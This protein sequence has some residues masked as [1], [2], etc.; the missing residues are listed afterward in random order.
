MY[1]N[2]PT[3]PPPKAS[4]K[5]ISLNVYIGHPLYLLQ[6]KHSLIQSVRLD[7]QIKQIKQLNPDI[8]CLQEVYDRQIIDKYKETLHEYKCIYETEYPTPLQIAIT[9]AIYLVYY[10]IA[11]LSFPYIYLL[12]ITMQ[13]YYILYY[14]AIG[15]FVGGN[16]KTGNIIFYKRNKFHLIDQKA[17]YFKNQDGNIINTIRR[18]G[19]I[20]ATLKYNNQSLHI[21][22]GHLSNRYR[23]DEQESPLYTESCLQ[24]D[25]NRYSEMA[26]LIEHI[27]PQ[28]SPHA[29]ANPLPTILCGDFNAPNAT[30]EITQM[31]KYMKN[32]LENKTPHHTW[33]KKNPMTRYYYKSADHQCDYIFY[34]NIQCK[35]SKIIFDKI[36]P[37]LS[38]HYGVMATFAFPHHTPHTH[39][40]PHTHHTAHTP[41]HTHNATHNRPTAKINRQDKPP[42]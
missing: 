41:H 29:K 16:I 32:T 2:S 15:S 28:Q 26:Q 31:K 13:L 38:D 17:Y 27:T 24:S 36:D 39:T 33:C 42:R 3:L 4:L 14:T 23:L 25:I 37:P 1:H 21:M 8:L 30:L 34:K 12:F 18:R 22:N 10:G 35:D 7:T 40:T 19:F 20:T 5:I 6:G 11:R 9:A